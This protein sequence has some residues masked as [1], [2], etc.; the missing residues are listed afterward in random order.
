MVQDIELFLDRPMLLFAAMAVGAM[1]GIAVERFF[2]SIERE[3]RAAYWRGRRS[4]TGG[5]NRVVKFGKHTEVAE[6]H[7]VNHAAEQLRSVMQAD[8]KPCQLLNQPERRL[9]ACIDRILSDEFPDWRVMGQVSLGEILLSPNKD[10]YNAIN[11][12][13]VDLLIV[14]GACRPLHAIEFQG[15]GHHLRN[16][17]AARDAIKREAL[18]RAGI[19]Y[20]EVAS[21]DTPKQLRDTLRK[22]ARPV[23]RPGIS[24]IPAGSASAGDSAPGRQSRG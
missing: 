11:A 21:G 2:N 10:A 1:I 13:R 8:F 17:T 4:H 3:Q 15:T 6:H 18:R 9:L 14:D 20:V 12:K 22:L 24:I 19:G 23:Q 16:D 5:V 7:R